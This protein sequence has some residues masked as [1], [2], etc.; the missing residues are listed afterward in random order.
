MNTYISKKK[1]YLTF[2]QEKTV[3]PFLRENILTADLYTYTDGPCLHNTHLACALADNVL[4]ALSAAVLSL[5]SARLLVVKS[6]LFLRLNSSCRWCTRRLSKSSPPRWVSPAVDFT[7][8]IP[9]SMI[10]RD[11]SKVPPPRSKIRTL[12][13][14]D[15]FWNQEYR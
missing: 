1:I 6:F 12:R 2:L 15:T 9:S 14:F 3:P 8:N 5:L 13:S 11:T 10:R 4:L 7:S